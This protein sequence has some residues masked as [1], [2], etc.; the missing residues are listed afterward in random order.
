MTMWRPKTE[1]L[2]E[3]L[4]EKTDWAGS[5]YELPK[6]LS[7][8]A[9]SSVGQAISK[10]PV[11][12]KVLEKTAPVFEWIGENVEKPWASIITSPFS[13]DIPWKSGE[14]WLEHQK[15]EYDSWKS[16]TYVKGLAEFAMP[17]WWMPWFGWAGK[18]L[19]AL[20][21]TNKM[22]RAL[23]TVGRTAGKVHLP[24]GEVLDNTLFK[25]D[26]FKTVSLW[27]ENKP[28]LNSLVKAVGGASAFVKYPEVGE[29]ALDITK[30]ALVK[31][32]VIQDMRNGV[33]GLLTPRLQKLGNPIDVLDI[34]P[35]G[36]VRGATALD[37][38]S[39]Y[40]SDLIEGFAKD[41]SNYKF[42]TPQG[43][44]FVKDTVDIINEVR[45][46]A[47]K[48]GV[49]VPK[50]FTFHRI[51]KGIETEEKGIYELSEYGSKFDMA[52]HRTSMKAGATGEGGKRIV[53]YES[54]PLTVINE[55][56]NHYIKRIADKRFNDEVGKLGQTAADKFVSL[57]P[58]E[59]QKITELSARQTA[60]KY[61]GESVSSIL[62]RNGTRLP[63]ATLAKIRRGMP[64]IADQLDQA[65]SFTPE[66]TDKIISAMGI[67]IWK[68]AKITPK[69]FKIALAQFTRYTTKPK[70]IS[71]EASMMERGLFNEKEW[72]KVVK[73]N[74]LANPLPA[75]KVQLNLK[76]GKI[77]LSELDEAIHSLNIQNKT[78]IEA[79]E[80]V[81]KEIYKNMTKLQKDAFKAI[82][83]QAENILE[84]T[85]NELNPLKKSRTEWIK[86]YGE[87]FG[88]G[89]AIFK[90]HPAFRNLIF[91]KE[92]VD[93]AEPVLRDKGNAWLKA[94]SEVSGV[95]RTLIAAM[96]F[97]AP[98]IQG[99]AVL[100]RNPVAWAKG[101]IR[102][103]EFFGKPENFYKYMSEPTTQALRAERIAFGG[104]SQ[105]F[106]YMEAVPSLQAAAKKVAGETGAK[107]V[108]STYG[109]FEAAYSGF[110]EVAR[111]E[112]WKALRNKAVRPDGTID[113]ALARE[114][115][116]TIDRM[117]GVMSTEALGLSRSQRNFENAFV[118][119]APRYTRA[120]L[121][122]VAD[123]FKGG[124]SGAEA[125]KSL[126]ALMASG[127]AM[128]MGA[129]KI[130]GQQPNLDIGSANFMTLKMG[131]KRVGIGGSFYGIARMMANVV[132]KATDE[133]LDLIRIS[134]DDNPFIKFMYQRASPLTGTITN[135][136]ENENY[137]GEP[138]E[139]PADWGRYLAE[140]VTPIALQD[141]IQGEAEPVSL[142][143]Q[144]FGARS[145]PKSA[146]ELQQEAKEKI[147]Q[148]EYNL[149]YESLPQ[150]FKS[151]INKRNE[152]RIFQAEIDKRNQ[153]LG[154]TLSVSFSE[155]QR[156]R[157]DAKL[158]FITQ[159]EQLEKAYNDGFITGND[160]REQLRLSK[161][162]YGQTLEHI[163]SNPRYTD[164]LKKLQE[165]KDISKD[166]KGDIAYNELMDASYSGRF[167]NEYGMFDF[168]LY[169]QF[170]ESLRQ[171][172]GDSAWAYVLQREKQGDKDLPPLA[173]EYEKAKE[174]LKP[175]WEII[176]TVAKTFNIRPE[177]VSR[178]PRLQAVVDK[179]RRQMRLTNPTLN[180]YY[181]MFYA[182]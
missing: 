104:T 29:T 148:E 147:A 108:G 116:R 86:S 138:F 90:S 165:P 70:A 171:K 2:D 107:A 49:K 21:A 43:K 39:A 176:N 143:A 14:S 95:G 146:W 109:R 159:L 179:L 72:L 141:V 118:F 134:K 180:Y 92:V 177:Q 111:N 24:T 9:M 11:L 151:E 48:E 44:Q 82:M 46:L 142:T 65:L 41:P 31:R 122:Y 162:G 105:T 58:E 16:P 69:E 76:A 98:F 59:A 136:I 61:L 164:V 66:T 45:D 26:F 37:G 75:E 169:N 42:A 18:G 93:L 158:M 114:V 155:R 149:P 17:L 133:P 87:G 163:D 62:T 7:D 110:G 175:Y 78:A 101:V 157:E 81:S 97:S 80:N 50:D 28:V 124:I 32:A 153:Q 89:G 30:R 6:D 83:E 145:F 71:T 131:E 5:L 15:R 55:T 128:Y 74:K 144:V 12:P 13:P 85:K 22:A 121:S 88:T 139:S 140:K 123:L 127:M 19:K 152:V 182:S 117:T 172:Y 8:K 137:L 63:P 33:R 1:I 106:E 125:R 25:K 150:A 68:E 160:Y 178:Y 73:E 47:A 166:F 36:L 56:I 102:Q 170:R 132:G 91:P 4:K 20:G 130:T 3:E 161:H 23:E 174:V 67:A 103:F 173:Q 99:L 54:N 167:E 181:Q 119:F 120:S 64:E 96:D 94:M 77:L 53:Q 27:A 100:G 51:V 154:N 156:E 129:C 40:L 79:V 57:F 126:S 115:A 112:M 60:A 52:R 113:E 34:A 168:N 84:S 38:S 10:V 135:I 35:D